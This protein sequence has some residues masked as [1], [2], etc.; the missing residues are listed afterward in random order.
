ML[1]AGFGKFRNEIVREGNLYRV[2]DQFERHCDGGVLCDDG[3]TDG[4]REHLERWVSD[5]SA[6]GWELLQIPEHENDFGAELVVKQRMLSMLA[7][8]S[9]KWVF[10]LDGDEA[11]DEIPGADFCSWVK[12]QADTHAAWKFH[13]T[14]LWRSA[15]W[16]R[17]DDGFD[18]GVF[19]K[20]WRW[21]PELHFETSRHGTHQAQFPK[22]IDYGAAGFAPFEIIHWGN[23]GKNLTWKAIQYAKGRGGV[24]RHI[25]FGHPP[26]T[27]MS[28]GEGWDV[29]YPAER[30]TYRLLG[31][32]PENPEEMPRPFSL[33]EIRTI[34]ELGEL[35]GL[36]GY[37]TVVVPTYNRAAELPRA[38]DSL[39]A[40]TNQRWVALVLDDGSTDH[41]D[42]IMRAYQARDPRIFYAR[43]P[44][45]R[46]G[47]AMNEIGMRMACEMTEF[48]SRLGSDDW[49]G[50]N[51]L[52]NDLQALNQG[53]GGVCY[54]C[55]TVVRDGQFAE[56][57]NK[58]M[59]PGEVTRGL[60]QGRFLASWANIAARTEVLRAVRARWGGFADA[61]LRNCEDFL[62]NVR[63]ACETRFVWRGVVGKGELLVDPE[64][65]GLASSDVDAV[66][67]CAASGGASSPENGA[68]LARD[69]ALTRELIAQVH[70]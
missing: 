58:S 66:W 56:I 31:S 1:I 15:H 50:P 30:P 36:A 53:T 20:L 42:A 10:W 61:R 44:T 48:W 37:F 60:L 34:R 9:P 69:E 52:W 2:L 19:C 39:I 49:W 25:H 6:W 29:T 46:G 57:C 24:D 45:N 67:T 12:E 3:S 41:T 13:Y 17:T 35:R 63:M 7:L 16:A 51:K 64:A 65:P 26:D 32:A 22:P 14:Q 11:L 18:D 23:Y 4:T 21:T 54:G 70:R 68:I 40:Q 62:V 47:V 8:A 28:T 27:S 5:H 55:Y 43:Y 59:L 33:D 38:L